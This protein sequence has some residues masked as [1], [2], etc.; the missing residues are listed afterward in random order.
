MGA[1]LSDYKER[2]RI[3]HDEL[4]IRWFNLGVFLSELNS[5]GIKSI[6]EDECNRLY[7]QYQAMGQY[8]SILAERIENFKH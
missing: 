6:G 2:V 3:E 5:E 1:K 7:R 4:Y 8:L